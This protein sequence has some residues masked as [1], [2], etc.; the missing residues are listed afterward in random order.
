MKV[1]KFLILLGGIAGIVGFFRPFATGRVEQADVTVSFT[2][3]QLVRGLD[4]KELVKEVKQ[5]EHTGR[6]RVDADQLAKQLEEGTPKVA[7]AVAILVYVPAAL[8]ALLGV[9]AVAR[10]KLGRLGG[11]V[12]LL[13][14]AIS[15]AVW[16]LLY[17]ASREAKDATVVLGIGAHLLLVAG[18]AGLLAG[19][20]ALV[21]PDRRA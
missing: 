2:A 16:M 15:S 1:W 5:V 6:T 4:F 11:L 3:Y 14:G 7:G 9:I 17:M 10:G 18:L 13:L 12:S 20:G 19:L 8:L 21:F